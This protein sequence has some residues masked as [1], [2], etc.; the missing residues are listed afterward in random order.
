[1][2][3]RVSNAD[4]W[5]TYILECGDG[6]YYVGFTSDLQ[7]RVKTHQS[8]NGPAYTA[9]RLPVRLAFFEQHSTRAEAMARDKQLKGWTHAK[10][11]ALVSGDLQRLRAL[12]RA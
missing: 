5:I 12:T 7:T 8:G 6:S 4:I 1:V 2:S 3:R 11:A 9:A 10:K